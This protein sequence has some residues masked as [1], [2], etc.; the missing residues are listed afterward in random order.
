MVLVF[1]DPV[2]PIASTPSM[3][4]CMVSPSSFV[5]QRSGSSPCCLVFGQSHSNIARS[6]FG[7]DRVSHRARKGGTLPC[8]PPE[9]RPQRAEPLPQSLGG[10]H[11]H[12]E[13]D[14]GDG[15]P[16]RLARGLR[17]RRLVLVTD[18]LH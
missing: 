3:H 15:R 4:W 14:P 5:S 16:E 7:R 10:G 13:R 17:L 6:S 9:L 12:G 1:P 11:L 8:A 18:E 2:P